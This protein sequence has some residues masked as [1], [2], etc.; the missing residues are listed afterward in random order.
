MA[1]AV[2]GSINC[3]V[4]VYVERLPR[5]GETLLASACRLGLGGKGAN[6]AVAARRLGSAVSLIGRV[7]DD[8]FGQAVL[9]EL[10]RFAL[11]TTLVAVDRD[12]ATG[13][14]MIHVGA[15][16]ENTIAIVAGGNGALGKAEL[17]EGRAALQAARVLLLQLEVPLAT[18]LAAA[19]VV[20]AAGGLAI[21]DPAPAP[22]G[23]LA[24]EVLAA[25]D[26][27][28]PNETETAALTGVLPRSADDGVAAARALRARGA[29]TAI[30]K[31]GARGAAFSGP[32]GEG[33]QP[34]FPVAAIDSVAAGDCF[35]G[36]LAHLLARG[37]SSLADAVRYAAA[38]GALSTT[39][40]GAADAAPS[41]IEVERLLSGHTA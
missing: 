11:D 23:G 10:R 29:G 1:V 30:V 12:G 2:V 4:I 7:G 28:T 9:G 20:R 6:Q 18:S 13:M 3:D 37:S 25:I 41:L 8:A 5:P 39:R 33:F 38:A 17:D 14:A 31:L 22:V 40:M 19:A 26:I 21:L 32:S 34:A 36:A 35:N 16:G 27:L 24:D 15:D